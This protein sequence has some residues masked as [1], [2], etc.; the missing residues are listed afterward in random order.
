MW[1]LAVDVGALS[2]FRVR[3]APCLCDRSELVR[4]RARSSIVAGRCS[5]AGCGSAAKAEWSTTGCGRSWS[6]SAMTTGSRTTGGER[7]YK[8]DGKALRLR[9]TLIFEDARGAELVKIEERMLRV[10][11]TMEIE[12]RAGTRVAVVKKAPITP[13]R[14]RWTV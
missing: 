14:E 6:R 9:Q 12:D 10:R 4:A 8:V 3:L 7:V 11:D 2:S 5:G 13:L 1:Q